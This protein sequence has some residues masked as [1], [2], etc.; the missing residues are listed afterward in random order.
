MMPEDGNKYIGPEE[1]IR[2]KREYLIPCAYHFYTKPMQIVRG[3][4][5]YL[6]DHTGKQYIDCYAG[7]SVVGAG[8]C[9]PEITAKTCE[10]I[11][12]LQHTTTIFLNQPIV[13][14]AERF[15]NIAPGRLQKSFFCVSGTEAN[16]GALLLAQLHTKRH[17]FIAL[18][19]GLSGRS[20]LTMS[21]TGLSFWRTDPAPVGGV[22]FAPNPNCYRCAFKLGYPGCDLR[23]AEQIKDVVETSTSREVAAMIVE[24]I[25][26]NG[27]VVVPPPG[28]FARVKEILEQY[29]ILLIVDEIQ[30]GFGRTGKMFA[31]EHWGVEPDIMTTAKFLGNGIPIGAFTTNNEI[32]SSYTRPGASTFGGNPVAAVTAMATLDFIQKA[33]LA[34]RA[35]RLGNYLHE[36]LCEL[37]S[38]Y[39]CVGDVRGKGLFQGAELVKCG[40]A[41]AT[42]EAD[43]ILESMKDSGVLVGKT[44]PGRNVIT[45]Q[46]PLVITES[47][48]DASIDAFDRALGGI[49]G[50]T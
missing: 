23:C 33:Q 50:T 3:E 39:V 11:N 49:A 22:S 9:N 19:H 26:G 38:K 30:S 20:K 10:Q 34:S 24:S 16:E 5:Q 41:P 46:P 14:L 45:F 25:Q 15:A 32:A 47:D 29:G 17:E 1:I 40:K 27:G 4:M 37:K 31:I 44:G 36:R 13:D 42:D 6:Y 12:T 35:E 28:Y 21:L 7:V 18:R 8:H 2:K 48:I 43:V